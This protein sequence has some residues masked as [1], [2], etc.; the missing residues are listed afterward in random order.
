MSD[1][2]GQ[3]A[4]EALKASVIKGYEDA[5]KRAY[6]RAKADTDTTKAPPDAAP[7]ATGT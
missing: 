5:A 2:N 7:K 3:D 6:E 4:G 1:Q